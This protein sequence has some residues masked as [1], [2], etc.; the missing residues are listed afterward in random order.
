[1]EKSLQNI[2]SDIHEAYKAYT[3]KMNKSEGKR[4]FLNRGHYH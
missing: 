1:M 2:L 4:G 3:H